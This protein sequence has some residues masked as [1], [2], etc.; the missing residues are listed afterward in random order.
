MIPAYANPATSS[1]QGQANVEAESLFLTGIKSVVRRSMYPE[2]E[3]A[4]LFDTGLDITRVNIP[5]EVLEKHPDTA[6]M[7]DHVCLWFGPQ[8]VVANVPIQR[9]KCPICHASS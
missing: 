1:S 7:T 3:D 4:C 6:E 9:S 8:S 5:F 2:K